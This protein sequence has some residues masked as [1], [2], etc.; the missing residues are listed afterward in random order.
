M[1]AKCAVQI[2]GWHRWSR[3]DMIE[4]GSGSRRSLVHRGVQTVVHA[5]HLWHVQA[6]GIGLLL[7]KPLRAEF[8]PK[9]CG[10]MRSVRSGGKPNLRAI[11]WD[12]PEVENRIQ[13]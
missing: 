11:L 5:G 7:R 8:G 9:V 2:F 13:E 6:S 10:S 1:N 12:N 4:K 3:P